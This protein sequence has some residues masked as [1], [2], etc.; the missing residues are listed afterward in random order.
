MNDS[1]KLALNVLRILLGIG[2]TI[3]ANIVA[4]ANMK[5]EIAKQI[6]EIQK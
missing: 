1:K 2:A 4:N 3:A 6:R 5:E